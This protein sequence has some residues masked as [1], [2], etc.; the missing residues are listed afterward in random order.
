MTTY[1]T[2]STLYQEADRLDNQSL[3][4]FI[5]QIMSMR[6]R[7]EVSD[8]QKKEADLL[9]KINQS[10]SI[11]EINQ[12]RFLNNK[13]VETGVSE[14]EQVELV[15]LLEK[16]EKLNVNRI[17]YLTHLARLRNISVRELMNQLGINTSING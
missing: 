2:L 15:R 4:A 12:F 6:L 9:K 8:S 13:R 11:P 10:L 5:A 14:Q 1:S 3:D 7:R 17:K 16:I